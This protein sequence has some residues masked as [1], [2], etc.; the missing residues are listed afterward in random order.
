MFCYISGSIN[1]G[2]VCPK[3]NGPECEVFNRAG[4]RIRNTKGSCNFKNMRDPNKKNEQ[5]K[6]VNPLKQSKRGVTA[7]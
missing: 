4:V 6:K 1:G 7:R 2:F 3:S 5:G